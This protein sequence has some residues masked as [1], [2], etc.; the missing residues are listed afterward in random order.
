MPKDL[1]KYGRLVKHANNTLRRHIDTFA[2]GYG[3]TGVQLSIIDFL[4]K[5]P[6]QMCLQRDIETEFA[7]RRSS[8]TTLLQRMEKKGLILRLVAK[9]DA[10]QKE[11][12]LTKKAQPFVQLNRDYMKAQRDSLETNF[13]QEELLT[14]TKVLQFLIIDEVGKNY[15]KE[16][17]R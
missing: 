3:L 6:Q 13:S 2:A 12:Q 4:G 17:E 15:G 16:R 11:I 5:Y 1:S 14:F 7:I 9:D 10:R 8:A